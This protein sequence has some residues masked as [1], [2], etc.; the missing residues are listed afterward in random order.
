MN[1]VISTYILLFFLCQFYTPTLQG[2]DPLYSQYMFS[3]F[4]LNPADAGSEGYTAINATAREQWIGIPNSPKNHSINFQTRLLKNSFIIK[5]ASLRKK[6]ARK[7][8]NGKVGVGAFIYNDMNGPVIRN[9]FQLTYAY[10]ITIARNLLSFGI[11]GKGYQYSIDRSKLDLG[12]GDPWVNSTDFTHFIPDANFGVQYITP[13]YHAGLSVNEL[14]Q[15]NLKLGGDKLP[16][17]KT[18]RHYYL[19][20]SY[21]FEINRFYMVEPTS[22]IKI[23]EFGTFQMDL[24]GKLYYREDYWGGLSYRTGSFSNSESGAIILFGGVRVDKFYFGYA[25]DYTL[26]NIMGHT[27]G[28]HEFMLSVKF[29]DNARRYRWLNRY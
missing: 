24:S 13:F 10:H 7:S 15:S 18:R 2:A 1:R 19:T 17:S 25:F 3:R 14:F 28:T 8:R 21:K 5:A 26:S 20:G 12:T 29:G 16:D 27:L 9:G 22:L 11:A 4:L 23:S 6:F